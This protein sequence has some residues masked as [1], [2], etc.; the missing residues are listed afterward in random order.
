M[1]YLS[2]CF[3]TFYS[4]N[5]WGQ[6]EDDFRVFLPLQDKS[7]KSKEKVDPLIAIDSP[8]YLIDLDDDGRKEKLQ[9]SYLNG[10]Q[11]FKIFDSEN[12]LLISFPLEQRGE[13]AHLKRA[14]LKS[15]GQG[16]RVLLLSFFAGKAHYVD[17]LS[18]VDTYLL[19][20]D[21][22]SLASLVWQKGPSIWE[23]LRKG[24]EY[25]RRYYAPYFKD[26]NGDGLKEIYFSY[27]ERPAV[28]LVWVSK[29]KKWMS[30]ASSVSQ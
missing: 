13:D 21:K 28:V 7:K 14:R 8:F 2:L 4:L 27:G 3:L 22:N 17:Y 10:E 1:I 23:E 12:K 6:S 19:T 9:V 29:Q 15:L 24:K 5:S 26:F 30:V 18:Q 20:F 25:H 16:K 11:H